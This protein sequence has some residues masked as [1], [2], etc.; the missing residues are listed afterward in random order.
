M[1]Q[2][3]Y[4]DVSHLLQIRQTDE[5]ETE[6]ESGRDRETRHCKEG[7]RKW[8]CVSVYPVASAIKV[9]LH[10]AFRTSTISQATLANNFFK[11]SV[12]CAC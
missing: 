10:R 8:L 4:F 3:L 12:L 2:K 5:G 6:T 1:R 11:T 7:K 9:V